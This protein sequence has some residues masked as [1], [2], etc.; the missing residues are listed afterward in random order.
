VTAQDT[1]Q[2]AGVGGVVLALS[3]AD[4]TATAGRSHLVVD[5]SGFRNAYGADFGAR[6][7]LV[8][9]PAC[10]LTTPDVP[11]CQHRTDLGSTNDTMGHLLSADVPV[12]GDATAI[13]GAAGA[14]AES[15]SGQSVASSSTVVA[16]AS[17]ASSEA[18]SYT[19]TSLSPTYSWSVGQQSGSFDWSYPLT[20]PPSL[21]GPAPNL[22]L[23]YDSQWA[24]GRTASSNGQASW[25]GA[26]WDLEPGYIER[27][28][29]TCSDDG[30][31]T[32]D[33][34]WFS[35]NATL[36]WQGHATPIVRDDTTGVWH[37]ADDSGLRIEDL[38]GTG[39]ANAPGTNWT[40]N[41]EYW[42][43]TTKD[44]TQ[45]YFGIGHRYAGDTQ[46]TG[47]ALM[48]PVFG[49]HPWEP[50]YNATFAS[51]WCEQGYRWN[52]DYVVDPR[53]NSMTYFYL[54]TSGYTSV[55]NG[56]A[57]TSYV[58]GSSL[59]RIEYGTRAGTED[60]TNP[61]MRML[62][63]ISNRCINTCQ[64]NTTDYPDSPWDLFCSSTTSCPNVAAP[65]HWTP[66]DL[67]TMLTQVWTGTGSTYRNV[68]GWALHQIFPDTADGT[69]P[70][71]WLHDIVH[72]G[73]A[74]DGSS[75]AEPAVEFGGDRYPNRLFY[76]TGSPPYNHYRMTLVVNGTGGET[77]IGYNNSD[78]ATDPTVDQDTQRCFP[79][80]AGYWLWYQ[81]YTVASVTDRDLTGGSPDELWSYAYSTAGS[82]TNV[83]WHFDMSEIAPIAHRLWTDWRGYSTVTT[84]HGATGGPQTV[85]TALY[86][87]GMNGDR[88]QA[89]GFGARTV[90]LTDS[91][92]SGIADNDQLRGRVRETSTLDGSTVVGSTIT[93]PTVT[94]TASRAQLDPTNDPP[95]V[96]WLTTEEDTRTRST[97]TAG[98]WR[99]T[100]TDTTYDSTYGDPVDVKD[101]GDTS[102]STDD[103]CAHTDYARNTTGYL[104]TYPYNVVTTDCAATPGDSDYLAGTHTNYDGQANG[105]A[106]TQGLATQ[107]NVLAS[108][109]GGVKTF[110][111]RSKSEYDPYG[112]L[113]GT[114]DA[115]NH[116]TSTAYTPSTGSAATQSTT[117]NPLGW[118]TTTVVDPG[119][120][121]PTS[122]SDVNG[123]VTTARYDP[124]G[125][126]NNVWLD[127]RSSTST[128]NMLYTY[129]VSSS[130]PNWVQTQKLGPN[131]VQVS[132]YDI[133]DGQMRLRQT[134]APSTSDNGG[135]NIIDTRYDARGLTAKTSTFWN[136]ASTPT[137]TLVSFADTDVQ[138]QHRYTYD[139]LERQTIDALWSANILQ[140][141]TSTGYV[142][143]DAVTVSPPTGGTATRTVTNAR[144]KTV[145]LDQY[146]GSTPTGT[147]QATTYVYD[148][149]GRLTTVT[150]PAQNSWTTTYDLRSRA[151]AKTDP[152]TGTTSMTYDDDA[153]LLTT[154]DARG[155]TLAY[156]YDNIDRKTQ[157]WQGAVSTGTKLADWTYDTL[158]NGQLTT[159]SRYASGGTYT[160]A[161]TGFDDAYRPLGTTVTIPS[162]EGFSPN[163]W[164]LSQTYNVD[165]SVA[166]MTYPATGGLAAET[167]NYSYDDTGAPH[168]MASSSTTYVASTWYYPW[169]PAEQ[170]DLAAT[171]SAHPEHLSTFYDEA[172]GRQTGGWTATGTGDYTTW[173]T[174]LDES[175]YYD[176]AGNI[177][178]K[179]TT[180]ANG[181]TY[182]ECYQY[183]GLDQLTQAWTSAPTSPA[184]APPPQP[185]PT[186]AVSTPTGRPTPTTPSA[187]AK[188]KSST[189]RP[190][191][192]PT[193]TATRQVTPNRT[194]SSP[195]LPPAPLSVPAA[196][197]T[198]R[199]ATPRPAM[200]CPSPGRH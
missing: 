52:L 173:T 108:V 122:V 118:S 38:T 172:T 32:P 182:A 139:N 158:A 135:R 187:T 5:Y 30:S 85:T 123:K 10:A 178:D 8:S 121:S 198:T 99:W 60:G 44:G 26:G 75:L 180:E 43:V 115:L 81:K 105:T 96:A 18:G 190:G 2:A 36:M 148:R 194:S 48:E 76:G 186:S 128:P 46:F 170:T 22:A 65:V 200:S 192:P 100:D 124:L 183:D 69:S 35:Y 91:Q 164:T 87:R 16:L 184:T 174:Q 175:Y 4:G 140:W 92:T 127:N 116:K 89:G 113:T 27:S 111:Q 125:R 188:P 88:T 71:L 55:N 185:K 133:Y 83:L 9:L 19:A 147:P 136:S 144:G 181:T 74:A 142:G 119:H 101:Y 176:P 109:S 191:T 169:G 151:T 25:I 39:A 104:I 82:S 199:P 14:A 160:V 34:C 49:N 129:N 120:G 7:R 189:N 110:K 62:F 153:R 102:T 21:G 167:V 112:R 1:A 31:P 64:Q 29:R 61:P 33:L 138:N 149:L 195:S 193:P 94:Q 155:T 146:L 95:L 37:A 130:S 56:N 24:D 11:A 93:T 28:Y 13:S 58:I 145:E 15:V 68:D 137:S 72:T 57:V 131:G 59:Q 70:S 80:W 84:T 41:N 78:C 143:S 107:V 45:Y 154:T 40:H 161:T 54:D 134:Q 17:G 103:R 197:A 50:C 159:S 126:L 162:S 73:Y 63:G 98:G 168:S 156:A 67:T 51:A 6:L 141:Q 179:W 196:T 23:R 166:S 97:V 106:P 132:S 66:Y 177:K 157:E 150:D 171:T 12:G 117:T 165:G 42:R 163:S 90:T 3:R 20:V 86:Y 77:L 53:G 114:Y 152:D 79:A 47:G